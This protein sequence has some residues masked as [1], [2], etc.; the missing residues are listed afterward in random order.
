MAPFAEMKIGW[1]YYSR[2][3]K[4]WFRSWKLYGKY[5]FLATPIGLFVYK[6]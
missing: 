1:N 6:K 5:T 4:S 3:P 2:Y